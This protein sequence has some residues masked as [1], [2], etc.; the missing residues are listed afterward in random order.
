M[1]IAGIPEVIHDFN[2]YVTGNKLGGVTGEVKVP[3]LASVTSTTSGAGILGEYESVVAGHYGSMEQEIPFRC[4]NA[5]YFT[6]INPNEAFEVTLRGSI[7]YTEQATMKVKHMGMRIVY[8]GRC[9]KINI[10]TV[11]QRGS[12]DSSV[13]LEL[14][15]IL[16]EMDGQSKL[17]LDK[18][19]GVFKVDG[20]DLLAEVKAQT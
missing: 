14:F 12:M 11:K 16:I 8:R 3:E 2:L 1:A 17:E 19:N 15:Y 5:D 6:L 7:Q 10:G 20:V 4:I 18:L 13:T 9:K